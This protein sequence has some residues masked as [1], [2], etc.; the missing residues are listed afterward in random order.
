MREVAAQCILESLTL[1]RIAGFSVI[2][3][4]TFCKTTKGVF[5]IGVPTRRIVPRQFVIGFSILCSIT[6]ATIFAPRAYAQSRDMV[7][8]SVSPG[9]RVTL[10]GHHPSWAAAA[11]DM[12]A[13]PSD[14]SLGPL[15]LVLARSPQ[16]QQAFEQFLKAQQDPSSPDYHHWLTPA[17]MGQHFGAS[18]HDIDAITGWLQSQNLHVDSVANSRMRINFSGSASAVANA[19]GTEMH[20]FQVDGQQRMSITAEPQIPAAL[21]AIVKSIHGLYSVT[22]S[23]AHGSKTIQAPAPGANGDS[24]N[25]A[26]PAVTT[27]PTSHFL[28]AGD[29][30]KIYD[31]NVGSI[32]GSG[33]TI[34]V[35]GQARVYD[36]DIINF[37]MLAGLTSKTPTVKVP[38]N[39]VDPGNP[40]T[41]P[42]P[43]NGKPSPAQEEATLDVTRATSIAPGATIDLVV[44]SDSIT[45]PVEYVVD[46]TPVPAQ[47]MT[48]SF[49]SCETQGGRSQVDFWDSL[50]SQA[51]AEGISVFVSSGDAGA[52]GC[53]PFFSTPPA[54]QSL[55]VN[56]LCSSSY[57]TCV[58]G[59]EFADA[60]SPSQYWASSNGVHGESALGYI[61][62]GTWNEPSTTGNQPQTAASGGGVS[63]FIATPSWQTGPGVPGTQ[64]RYTPDI[65]FSS[66]AHNGYVA[67]FA[68]GGG[69]CVIQNGGFTS[70]DIFFGSSAT[71]P[72][73]AGI[74]ALLN[75]KSGSAQGNLNPRLYELAA[76]SGNNVF[77]DV[78]VASSG[79]SNCTITVPSM[80]NNSTPG[81]T[82]QTG[83]LSGYQVDAGYDEVTGL[84]SIDV[85]NLLASWAPVISNITVTSSVNPT[86][87]GAPVT[88]TAT[89]T[90]TANGTPTGTVTFLDNGTSIGAATLNA[91]AVA[92]L[93]TSILTVAV[94]PISASYGGDAT[95]APS[96]SA[97]VNQTVIAGFAPIPAPL[98]VTAGQ[99]LIIPLT[100]YAVAGSNLTFTLSCAGLPAK[101]SCTF[102]KNPVTPGPPPG[103]TLI[104]LTLGTASSKLPARPSNR[105][106]LPWT[107][108][109]ICAALAT[110]LAAGGIQPG[111]GA[112]LRLAFRV[113]VA[114]LAI[115]A[116][117]VGCGASNSS[118]GNSAYTGT[119]K[120]ATTFTVTATS[121]SITISIPVT[122]TVQ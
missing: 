93:S 19:L 116:V 59:T 102:D 98:T 3:I 69:A 33:Q 77:H 107:V 28:L 83:G 96:T 35:I 89:V 71:A 94:H 70:F 91:G 100:M 113:S 52:A 44:S 37:Q 112:R 64:G 120:G 87:L 39:S 72:D 38:P 47:I 17:E 117:V 32:D 40:E 54:S 23:P 60:N 57:V 2:A 105:N 50:F 26:V 55:G 13:V 121:S 36:Q 106:T 103:G 42:P 27:S 16:Q 20:Y 61:P 4:V 31:V 43:N 25:A 97:S 8:T 1:T 45:T 14:Q 46:T 118:G 74:A 51:A 58:G 65:A 9:S 104:H 95:F 122:V 110:V 48:I 99:N 62:E 81:P 78:T 66:S 67:C 75:Q 86:A 15:S 41:T 34:A 88:F 18:Q 109:I 7:V 10:N 119:P 108:F 114:T 85:G 84:G 63:A 21:S 111:R 6:A 80:C 79:V 90:G 5:M 29:F 92:T 101:T 56:V 24:G 53:D 76:I 30:A 73:M 12:G 22:M 82:G 115:T 68:A 11:N 49:S